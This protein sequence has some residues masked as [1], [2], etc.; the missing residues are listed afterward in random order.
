[1]DLD[2]PILYR[3][4]E[5]EKEDEIQDEQ[6]MAGTA[7]AILVLGAIESHRLRTERPKPSRLYLC[8]PQLARNPRGPTAWQILYNSRNDRAYITA[9]RL[10]TLFRQENQGIRDGSRV[11]LL[12]HIRGTNRR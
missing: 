8:R 4:L 9:W 5:D 12:V 11:Y 3:Q 2:A 6:L 1:M 7:M 10:S